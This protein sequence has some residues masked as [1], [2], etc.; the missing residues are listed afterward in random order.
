MLLIRVGESQF[1]G[2]KD[3]AEQLAR[4]TRPSDPAGIALWQP[5]MPA[6]CHCDV[7][8]ISP[9]GI[10]VIEVKG[11][12]EGANGRMPSGP[13]E[14][15]GNGRWVCDG[16]ELELFL[17]DGSLNPLGQAQNY[18]TNLGQLFR[19]KL[20]VADLYVRALVLLVKPQYA[21]GAPVEIAGGIHDYHEGRR[22][23]LSV[24]TLTHPRASR[25][26]RR[27][28]HRLNERAQITAATALEIL[29]LLDVP[30]FTH[31]SL[32]AMRFPREKSR[33]R[34]SRGT[35]TAAL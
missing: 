35:G 4:W 13:I 23:L 32:V 12:K 7:L 9:G 34:R 21:K 25:S 5:T 17:Q 16:V 19:E 6:G 33:Y 11:L 29:E 20:E 24:T 15:P 2:E 8:V 28:F 27:Y 10:V 18:A 30:G 22:G 26:F 14:T 31:E 1:A 3:V